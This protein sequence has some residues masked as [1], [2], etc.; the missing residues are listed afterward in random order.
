MWDP[1]NGRCYRLGDPDSVCAF[2]EVVMV[3][4]H[5]HIYVNI[6]SKLN[7]ESV[8]WDFAVPTLTLTLTLT[9]MLTL[10]PILG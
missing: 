2:N 4:N 1:N 3:F 8:S 10:T 7:P 5:E 6:Q 9:L